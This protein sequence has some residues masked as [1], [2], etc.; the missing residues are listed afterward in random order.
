M[1]TTVENNTKNTYDETPYVSYPYAQSS[2]AHLMTMAKLFSL[3][4]PDLRTAKVLELGC[5]TGGNLIPHALNYPDASFVG[6][7]LSKVQVD[8]AQKQIKELGLNN[9]ELKCMSITDIDEKFGEFDYIICH[10]VISWVPDFVR[11]KIFDV[12]A[13]NLSKKGVAYISYNTLPGWNMVRTIRDM[14]L[15]HTRG[16][17][18]PKE[19]VNQSRLLLDFVNDAL[20]GV[21]T[22]YAKVLKSEAELLSGQNDYYLRHDHLEEDNK[23]YYFEEFMQVAGS[24]GL[25]YLSDA[26]LSTMYLGNLPQKAADKL[27]ELNDIVRTEQY[28]DFITNR[29]F[30]STMLVHRDVQIN[31]NIDAQILKDFCFNMTVYVEKERKDIDIN[32]E[33]KLTFYFSEDKQSSMETTSPIMKA[34][35]YVLAEN[36][37]NPLNFDDLITETGKLL[38]GT[39]EEDVAKFFLPNALTLLVKGL[40]TIGVERGQKG[41]AN[42][43]KP[44]LA[45]MAFYQVN[46]TNN[47]WVTSMKHTTIALSYFDKAAVKYFDGKNTH[48]DIVEKLVKDAEN[49]V[50]SVKIGDKEVTD[51]KKLEETIAAALSDT[52]ARM[53]YSDLLV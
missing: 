1:V 47:L 48:A 36:R 44:K 49:K 23:Q 32:T 33:D 18:N 26:S 20:E 10:G 19:K 15:Y 13:K 42:T 35:F 28:M 53:A 31:R 3:E 5:A 52:V 43:E 34:I 25:K 24:K 40:L 11:E 45:P 38:K 30:R 22:P 16:F 29:R 12:C 21:E 46:H 9:V 41:K 27:N 4:T 14:M 17:D 51:K 6:V 37:F 50:I 8:E 2:P 7:D 39:N